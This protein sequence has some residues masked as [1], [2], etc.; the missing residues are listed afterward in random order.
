MAVEYRL[1]DRGSI[2]MDSLRDVHCNG[3][4]FCDRCRLCDGQ[5]VDYH[6]GKLGLDIHTVREVFVLSLQW[7]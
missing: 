5:F 6:G 2:M 4:L 3:A 7:R 1:C